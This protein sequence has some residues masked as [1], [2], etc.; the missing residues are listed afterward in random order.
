[1]VGFGSGLGAFFWGVEG[2]LGSGAIGF[3]K[4]KTDDSA[5]YPSYP[6]L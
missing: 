2:E 5:R 4:G 6:L 3:W 1:M